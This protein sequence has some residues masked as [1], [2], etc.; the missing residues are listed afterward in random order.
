VDSNRE[1][2]GKTFARLAPTPW[3][4]LF[5]G[6]DYISHKETIKSELLREKRLF[7]RFITAQKYTNKCK[8]CGVKIREGVLPT[9]GVRQYCNNDGCTRERFDKIRFQIKLP[10]CEGITKNGTRCNNPANEKSEFCGKH[11]N[12]KDKRK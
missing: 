9:G 3:E 8:M 2:I 6:R 10:K 11:Y 4:V 1:E 12:Q 7:K 5:R